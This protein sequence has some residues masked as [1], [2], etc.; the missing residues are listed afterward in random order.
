MFHEVWDWQQRRTFPHSFQNLLI[1]LMW[2]FCVRP[3][4][5]YCHNQFVGMSLSGI[6][7]GRRGL[8]ICWLDYLVMPVDKIFVLCGILL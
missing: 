4:L 5:L 6:R 2:R 7:I 3:G 8:S 1:S